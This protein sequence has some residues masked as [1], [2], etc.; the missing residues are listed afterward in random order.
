MDD[1]TRQRLKRRCAIEAVLR[2]DADAISCPELR[3]RAV[4]AA[5]DPEDTSIP[6][7]RWEAAVQ[8]WRKIV[9]AAK[10]PSPE[11]VPLPFAL[12]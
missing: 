6:K 5:P 9:C 7:R 4:A 10:P 2:I 11:S 12:P 8:K 1:L 3:L